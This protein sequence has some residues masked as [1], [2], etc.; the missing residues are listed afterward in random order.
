MGKPRLVGLI[1]WGLA[2]LILTASA[3]PQALQAFSGNFYI[4]ADSEVIND[5][6]YVS[7]SSVR[8]D[9]TIEGDLTVLATR[10]LL[11]T[12]RV[13]GDIV[14]VA[15]TASIEGEVSGSVRL[16]GIDVEVSGQ[17]GEEVAVVARRAEL[18]ASIGE[19]ALIWGLW[20]TMEGDLGRDLGGRTISTRIE[21]SVGRDVEVTV[22][23]LEVGPAAAISGDLGYR[24]GEEAIIDPEASIIGTVVRRAPL[25]SDIGLRSTRWLAGLMS[26]LVLLATG[27]VMIRY[28]PDSLADRTERLRRHPIKTAGRGLGLLLVLTLPLSGPALAIGL[29]NPRIALVAVGLGLGLALP[30]LLAYLV[31]VWIGLV[32][33]INRAADLVIPARLGRFGAFSALLFAVTLI[34]LL[35]PYLGP[36]TALALSIMALGV[37]WEGAG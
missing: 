29:G 23:R 7:A 33:V 19:D 16:I 8:I 4:V 25:A 21:G 2:A 13:E 17:V 6:L 11:V 30:A 35:V 14:G 26:F 27:R 5:N 24:S 9:G 31:L 28:R 36:V 1:G 37:V 10:H 3:A 18:S 20:L 32:P 15:P 22:D 12:G 34:L